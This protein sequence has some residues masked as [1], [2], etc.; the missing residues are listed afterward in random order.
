MDGVHTPYTSYLK[1]E[2]VYE[3][4]RDQVKSIWRLTEHHWDGVTSPLTKEQDLTSF[5]TREAQS[6]L[7]RQSAAQP[8]FLQLSYV[9]PHVPSNGRPRLGELLPRSADSP[10][11]RW[12]RRAD[13]PIWT[14]ISP[15]AG[16]MR[17]LIC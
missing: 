3:A 1:A 8:F 10:G 14:T 15:G 9:Q 17:M 7:A 2:G 12:L 4:Y 13:V 16:T 5:L 6:W 11:T